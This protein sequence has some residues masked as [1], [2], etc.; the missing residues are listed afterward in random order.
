[1]TTISMGRSVGR[2]DLDFD[3]NGDVIVRV[4]KR[5]ESAAHGLVDPNDPNAPTGF[6]IIAGEDNFGALQGE[7][8]GNLGVEGES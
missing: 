3:D 5:G 6:T 7:P 8:N 1:M 2:I 4:F